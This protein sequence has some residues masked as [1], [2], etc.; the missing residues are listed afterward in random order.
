MSELFDKN[1]D[2]LFRERFQNFEHTPPESVKTRIKETVDNKFHKTNGF[3]YS[4]YGFIAVIL[5]VAAS[6]LFST[7]QNENLSFKQTL[8]FE[9]TGLNY[10]NDIKVNEVNSNGNNT[11][12]TSFIEDKN[13]NDDINNNQ[14]QTNN[15]IKTNEIELIADAG[16]DLTICG[17][18]CK[19]N[20]KLSNNSSQGLW[21]INGPGNYFIEDATQPNTIIKVDTYGLYEL[22]WTETLNEMSS[23]DKINI[24]F[25]KNDIKVEAKIEN[26]TCCS[27]NGS[28]ILIPNDSINKYH[29]YWYDDE[30]ISEPSRNNL[31]EGTY[32]VTIKD[33]KGCVYK[34]KFFIK[35][36][37]NINVAFDHKELSLSVNTPVYFVNKTTIDGK[38]YK[39]FE[40]IYFIWK[41]NENEVSNTPEPE[42]SFDNSQKYNIKLIAGIDK[43]CVD[44]AECQIFVSDKLITCS[45]IFTP[46]GDGLN[47]IFVVKAKNLNNFKGVIF[48]RKG[49]IIYEWT[50]AEKGW[51]GKLSDGSYAESGTYFYV[52]S[53]TDNNGKVY[54]Y[55]N[56]F[57]LNR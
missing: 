50:D 8:N 13:I 44:S 52:I 6:F 1:M 33:E 3:K 23:S 29:F 31:S 12:N 55:K 54:Q 26:E 48:N 36:T 15:V 19:L 46:N 42:L 20:A 5:I 9:I 10:N 27:N 35:N 49:N 18:S 4:G 7:N 14:I 43:G 21:T 38:D 45:N 37:G 30:S 11:I 51:D 24:N 25:I 53:G 40:D 57:L 16:D 41:V 34:D 22:T 2:K 47:D 56:F 32:Y 39:V 17:L 28:I